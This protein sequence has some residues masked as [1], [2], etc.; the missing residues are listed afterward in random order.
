[1]VVN[2]PR[3]NAVYELQPAPIRI[4]SAD[5]LLP[6]GVADAIASSAQSLQH[7]ILAVAPDQYE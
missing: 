4:P 5:S 7:Q 3:E 1:M 6:E 2:Q